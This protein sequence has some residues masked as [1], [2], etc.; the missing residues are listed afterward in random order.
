[1]DS[2][3]LTSEER[4]SEIKVAETGD[5]N[6]NLM[7]EIEDLFKAPGYPPALRRD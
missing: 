2:D 3:F 4:V 5:L 1:M 6:P 7:T